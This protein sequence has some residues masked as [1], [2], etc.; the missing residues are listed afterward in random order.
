MKA[1]K[2]DNLLVYAS[3]MGA[4]K[5]SRSVDLSS[6]LQIYSDMQR[7][8]PCFAPQSWAI[9]QSR[10]L[11]ASLCICRNGVIP[12]SMLYST[13][14][15]VAGRAGDVQLAFSLQADMEAEGVRP[16]QVLRPALRTLR[17]VL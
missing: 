3:A 12:D 16:C 10:W 13:L 2:T 15:S 17:L 5:N 8:E 1:Q 6:A 4:C 7:C 14:M 11:D 9:A